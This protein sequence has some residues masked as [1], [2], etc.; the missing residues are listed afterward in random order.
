M[1]E[2]LTLMR[3]SESQPPNQRNTNNLKTIA[4]FNIKGGVGKTTSAVNI[5]YLAAQSDVKTLLWDLDP[6]SCA[7]WYLNVDE[8]SPQ[9]AMNI[10]R[11]KTPLGKL[12][13]KSSSPRLEVI[14][15][16]LSLRKLEL[17][18]G[19][20]TNSRKLLSKLAENLGERNKLLIFDCAPAFS[21]LSENIFSC[22]DTLVVPLLPS[23]LSLRSYEQ[24][25][26]YVASKKA[27]KKLQLFPFFTMVDRRRKIHNQVIED[28]KTL[29]GS[30]DPVIIPYSSELEK[31]GTAQAP[32][33]CFA[34]KSNAALAYNQLWKRLQTNSHLM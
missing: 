31:M 14:P 18:L 26:D 20:E 8:S 27:W 5:A 23:P 21:K 3:T 32:V 24:L 13:I 10:F 15:A 11:A 4:F 25:K 28:A 34:A 2:A 22:S 6:Q 12:R 30:E 1:V 7:S 19:E 17:L 29:V 9:K 16:D 33:H